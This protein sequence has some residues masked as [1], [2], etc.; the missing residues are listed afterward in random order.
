MLWLKRALLSLL[1]LL[2]LVM[3]AG[4]FILQTQ[5]AAQQLSQI[6]NRYTRYSLT[7]GGIEHSWRNPTQWNIKQVDYHLPYS[8]LTA[9]NIAFSFGLKHGSWRRPWQLTKVIISDGQ[10]TIDGQHL[11]DFA[12]LTPITSQVLQFKNMAVRYQDKQASFYAT[13]VDAGITPWQQQ[14]PL[15]ANKQFQLSAQT[16][17]Y[18]GLQAENLLV[19][20]KQ[21]AQGWQITNLGATVNQG[22]LT[23]QLSKTNGQGWHIQKLMVNNLHWQTTHRLTPLIARLKQLPIAQIEKA[24]LLN[25]QLQGANW[26]ADNLN[27]NLSQWQQL[28]SAP[29]GY[30]GELTLNTA[31]FRHNSQ[32]WDNLSLQASL[33]A[34]G[35]AFPAFSGKWQNG[36]IQATGNWQA[37]TQAL[38]L[39]QL[40]ATG[41]SYNLP[42]DSWHYWQQRLPSWLQQL[43][44]AHFSGS[45][46]SLANPQSAFPWQ[47]NSVNAQGQ[48]LQIVQQ[49]QLGLWQGQ[50]DVNANQATIN[51]IDL[52]QPSFTLSGDTQRI[53]LQ[54]FSA[55][56]QQGLL[57]GALTVQQQVG[58]PFH[59]LLAG[60]N[61]HYQLLPQWGW[62]ASVDPQ[63]VGDFHLNLQ[64]LLDTASVANSLNGQLTLNNNQGETQQQLQAGQLINSAIKN[65][66]AANNHQTEQPAA[67]ANTAKTVKVPAPQTTLPKKTAESRSA[68]TG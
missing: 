54:P 35:I 43:S 45:N 20:G 46:L 17:N 21:Q 50:I 31:T 41:I 66:P 57:K 14:S 56:Q 68:C 23:A 26:A 60:Q 19:E 64:G 62:S 25:L 24:N 12:L 61:S 7:I 32:S 47:F 42:S 6:I 39:S 28:A 8:Q 53:R 16:V 51:Q 11:A 5:W 4:Y 63:A 49:Q 9:N 27:V 55:L 30:T 52:Q 13:N 3:I 59:L 29:L 10:L 40:S 22:Q 33:L 48:G 36:I 18:Q 37:A 44:I 65:S 34:Q 67:R 38:T 58:Y 2:L 15:T 1:L